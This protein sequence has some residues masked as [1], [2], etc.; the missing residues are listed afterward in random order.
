[1]TEVRRSYAILDPATGLVPDTLLPVTQGGAHPNLAAHEL[2]GLAATHAHPFEATGTVATHA[3]TPHGTQAHVHPESE[4]TN[5][6]TDLAGKAPTHGH[7]YEASGAVATHEAALD[8]HPTYLTSAEG[9]VA[10]EASG[11]VTTHA[12][13]A[14]PH[15]GYLTPAEGSAAY[16][17]IGAAAAAQAASQPADSDLTAIAALTTTAFGRGLLALADAAA[18]AAN[19]THS[20]ASTAYA[21]GSFTVATGN[22]AQMVKRLQLT[23]TQRSTL[24]GTA[25]LRI[26]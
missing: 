18:L 5:L 8:P 4:V 10:Y 15:P 25:R 12:G 19:H 21:P 6:V 9:N 26:D 1:M 20:G 23:S 16:D 13:L 22:Y 2:L 14:D 11:A 17:A 7:P 24:Q 3:L